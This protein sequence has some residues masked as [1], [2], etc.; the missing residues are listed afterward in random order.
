MGHVGDTPDGAA[1]R[2]RHIGS[3][4]RHLAPTLHDAQTAPVTFPVH[5]IVAQLLP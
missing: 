5:V 3:E 1:E 4:L 2:K